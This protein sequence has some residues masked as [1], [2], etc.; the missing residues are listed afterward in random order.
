[1]LTGYDTCL[2]TPCFRAI[3]SCFLCLTPTFV[4]NVPSG[5]EA[6]SAGAVSDD[7]CFLR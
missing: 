5:R 7:V 4:E 6:V 2:R 3:I 1:M